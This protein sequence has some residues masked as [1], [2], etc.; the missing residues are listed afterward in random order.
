[1]A[2]RIVYVRKSGS[3]SVIAPAPRA[4]AEALDAAKRLGVPLTEDQAIMVAAG[5]DLP[6]GEEGADP[7]LCDEQDIPA[8]RTFRDAW[9]RAGRVPVAV[10]MA[11]AV[12]IAKTRVRVAR[13]PAFKSLDVAA[14]RA[15][16]LP[17]A[18][19]RD[20]RLS[21]IAA[22]KQRLR[23]APADARLTDAKDAT[24]LKSA[25]ETVI[26]EMARR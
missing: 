5:R 8:D 21:E 16:E 17:N 11:K 14:Q 19:E 9:T 12:E 3:V 20:A 15:F 24:A 25:M 4:V 1:M 6:T 10:D 7:I 26:A 13:E 23:D 2:K 18:A 22:E